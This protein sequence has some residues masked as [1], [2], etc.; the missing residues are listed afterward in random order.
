MVSYL[1]NI[2][3]TPT[4]LNIKTSCISY[5]KIKNGGCGIF[6]LKVASANRDQLF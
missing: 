4:Y 1:K 5:K 6:C 3:N 2:G